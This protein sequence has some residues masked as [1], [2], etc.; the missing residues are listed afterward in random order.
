MNALPFLLSVIYPEFSRGMSS[1]GI[2]GFRYPEDIQLFG[3]R[4]EHPSEKIKLYAYVATIS[5]HDVSWL[6]I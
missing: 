5:L 1:R 3:G 2:F 4:A 6:S